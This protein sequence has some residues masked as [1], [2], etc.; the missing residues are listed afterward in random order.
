M[1]SSYILRDLTTDE[2]K[3]F[4]R[5]LKR[6]KSEGRSMRWV[7]AHLVELYA[8]VGLEPLERAADRVVKQN[9]DK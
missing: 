6:A 5:A 7:V 8:C 9:G 3:D 2:S 1:P 4:N